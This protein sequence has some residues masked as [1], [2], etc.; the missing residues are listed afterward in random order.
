M[1][2]S[3]PV[4]ASPERVPK[5]DLFLEHLGRA[6]SLAFDLA[7]YAMPLS[8]LASTRTNHDESYGAILNRPSNL[9]ESPKQSKRQE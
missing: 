8:L 2:S 3:N 6:D 5:V 1:L 4:K 7:N 9:D